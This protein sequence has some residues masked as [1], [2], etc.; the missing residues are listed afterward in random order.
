MTDLIQIKQYKGNNVVSA[1][2]LYGFLGYNP[3]HWKRWYTKNIVDE[4][5]FDENIDYQTFTIEV[6]GNL[7]KD[8][9]ISLDMAKELSMLAKTEK[10]KQARKYFIECEKRSQA[11]L[12]KLSRVEML[13]L[14]LEAEEKLELQQKQLQLQAPKVHY[15]DQVLNSKATYVTNQIAK[16]L[17]TSAITLNRMLHD[18]GIQY[19]SGGTWVLYSQYQDKGY[20]KTKTYTFMD[21]QGEQKTSMQTVWTELGRKFIHKIF[22]DNLKM[23]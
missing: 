9:A 13:R 2:D 19:S 14:A 11:S 4:V 1:R 21:S 22:N 10:G 20:T 17:G 23:A 12:K 18:R 16:E 15:H 7:T 3:A 5:F 6:N 8:F